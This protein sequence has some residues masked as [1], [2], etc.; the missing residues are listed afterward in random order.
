VFAERKIMT[1]R[2]RQWC[3][4]ICLVLAAIGSATCAEP[5]LSVAAS[6]EVQHLA[7][8]L[9]DG[10]E[11]D[12]G[13]AWHLVEQ[14]VGGVQLPVQ[15]APASRAD[16]SAGAAPRCL[17]A[18]VPP[19][20][21]AGP[22]RRF[23]LAT[24]GDDS[25]PV[26]MR[27]ETT[28]DTTLSLHD[29]KRPVLAYNHGEITDERVPASDARR[30]RA[31]Y[32]HP[33]WG[34]DGEVITDDFPRDHYHHH[35]V[36]WAWPHVKIDETHYNLWFY[37][38]IQQ[39]HVGWI[40]RQAGPLGAVLA[41]ENG[42]F[43]GDRKVMIER[44]WLRVFRT[45]EQ[46]RAIDVRL[47]FIPVDRPITLW[48]AG[49]KSYGGL[50]VRFAPPSPNDA[51]IT[52]PSGRTTADLP[53]TPLV[54]ADFVSTFA[55]ADGPSGGAVF[56][57]PRH[58]D[59]PPSW[60]TRHYGPLCVGWPGIKP[61]TFAPGESIQLDYRLWVHAGAPEAAAIQKA[62]DAYAAGEQAAWGE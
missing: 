55:G 57:S 52:V 42:W 38:D 62:Y 28:S 51:T 1:N 19:R 9:P 39:R 2:L 33:V 13:A 41:V 36:F 58:P 17:M 43:V 3:V 31:C 59:F 8:A 54:W 11:L 35:G 27:W 5:V 4:G 45:G 30:S 49:G 12:A 6:T 32:I 7:V 56:V 24:R 53:D 47:V 60:L 16:G 50:N 23:R 14:G 25:E 15:L 22:T 20:D 37:N 10:V 48:G 61:K 34:L 44:V 46:S 21:G 26:A 40:A 29:G 18:A